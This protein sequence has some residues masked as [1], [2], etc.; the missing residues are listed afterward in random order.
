MAISKMKKEEVI[1]ELEDRQVDGWTKE[2]TVLELKAFLT[3]VRKLTTQEENPIKGLTTM[4]LADLQRKYREEGLGEPGALT[5]GLLVMELRNHLTGTIPTHQPQ[6]QQAPHAA[7]GSSGSSGSTSTK[8]TQ[9]TPKKSSSQSKATPKPKSFISRTTRTEM[10]YDTAEKTTIRFGKHRGMS[11][12]AAM[13][14]K[15]QYCEW[16]IQTAEMEPESGEDLNHFSNWLIM[17]GFGGRTPPTEEAQTEDVKPE[18]S[19]WMH[20]E[21]SVK[22]TKE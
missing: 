13:E 6:A 3:A 10:S 16:V 18:D 17:M 14:S 9:P 15:P 4:K 5:R 19:E 2:Q 7:T 8:A 1:K 20:A 12:Q 11:Y 21:E 22:K